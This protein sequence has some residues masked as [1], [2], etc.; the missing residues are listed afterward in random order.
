M[1]AK[2]RYGVAEMSLMR[3]ETYKRGFNVLMI[4]SIIMAGA[5]FTGVGAAWWAISHKPSP[6]YF[7]AR[8]DGGI[9][10]LV[11]VTQPYLSNGEISNFA[12]E[13]IT[14]SLTLDFSN[15]RKS[16]SE[17]SQYYERPDGWNNFLEA[18]KSSGTL[19]MITKRRLVSTVVANGATV[20]QSGV[21]H[22]V[23][24]WV[25]QVPITITYQSSSQ[26]KSETHLVEMVIKRLP[27]WQ[28][29]RGVGITRV[30]MK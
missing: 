15:Y 13:A 30:L 5:T 10:P 12:V 23:Y 8:E 25:V 2:K 16:L 20:A 6:K 4:S 11:P 21:D 27:T 3:Y 28:T 29:P 18:L 17:A 26:Q 19:D 1:G 24:S 22:G 9:V 14:S 7:M